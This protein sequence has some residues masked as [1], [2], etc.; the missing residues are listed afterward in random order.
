MMMWNR[1]KK[2]KRTQLK[3]C[4]FFFRSVH[5]TCTQTLIFSCRI[6][7]LFRPRCVTRGH[8]TQT[9]K[10]IALSFVS[11]E[12]CAHSAMVCCRF[13][14][15]VNNSF[16]Y[17][18]RNSLL[19][20]N[21]EARREIRRSWAKIFFWYIPNVVEYFEVEIDLS[22]RGKIQILNNDFFLLSSSFIKINFV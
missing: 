8:C 7:F 14:F 19:D 9:P 10:F 5:I 18:I 15:G 1:T 21:W 17:R 12:L 4:A 11:C 2:K 3:I 20:G 22:T 16:V 13:G 6:S